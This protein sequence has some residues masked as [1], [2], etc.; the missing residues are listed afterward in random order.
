MSTSLNN[1]RLLPSAFIEAI[2]NASNDLP[3]D[4]SEQGVDGHS[5]KVMLKSFYAAYT[6]NAELVDTAID[7][8]RELLASPAGVDRLI[9]VQNSY[10]GNAP[11]PNTPELMA[12]LQ[13]AI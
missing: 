10:V 1:G 3:Y 4:T 6:D 12:A 7:E 5:E 8:F 13:K 2:K 11:G 9:A